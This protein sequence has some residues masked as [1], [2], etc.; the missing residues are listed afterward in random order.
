MTKHFKL[1]EFTS[2]STAL[3]LSIRNELPT[4]FYSNLKRLAETLESAREV[5]GMPIKVTSGYRCKALNDAV[6]GA[7]NSYHMYG[8][9]ADVWCE[10][11]QSLFEILN[12]LPHVELIYHYP[13]YIHFA[14]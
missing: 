6:H 3:R 8:R 13:N 1:S 11:M 10:D 14:V 2:S 12:S 5:L 4:Q 9:A 7:R